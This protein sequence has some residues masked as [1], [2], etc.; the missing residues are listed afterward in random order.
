[1]TQ[2]TN[3]LGASPG[4]QSRNALCQCGSGEKYKRCCG[5]P[6]KQA[7]AAAPALFGPEGAQQLFM[8]GKQLLQT[9]QTMAAMTAFVRAVQMD[10]KHFEAHHALGAAL[11]QSGRLTDA[12]AILFQAVALRPRSAAAQRDLGASYDRQNHHEAA[13]EAYRRAVEL[14]PD[15][16]DVQLRLG[17]LYAMYSR[18]EEAAQCLERAAA[19]AQDRVAAALFRSDARLLRGDIEGA[20]QCARAAVGLAPASDATHGTLGGLLYNQG[21]FDEAATSF[22]AALKLNPKAVKCWDG[23][24]HC[25]KYGAADQATLA[26]MEAVAQRRDLADGD[27][28]VM[29]F[30]IGKVLDD[31]GEYARAMQQFDAANR[32]R[33]KDL[34]FDRAGLAAMVDKTIERFTPEFMARNATLG[35]QDETP[36]FVVGMYRSGTTLAEQILS[37]HPDITAGGELTVWSPTDIEPDAV[38][39]EFDAARIETAVAKY[40]NALRRIGPAA[41][42]VTD[43]L[44]TNFFRLGAIHTLLPRA[45][46]IHCTRDPV[47][48]CFSVYSTLFNTRMPFAARLD[49]LV[50]FYEQYRRMMDHWRRVL[51][52]GALLDV[53]YERLV[54]DREAETRR[55]V[56]FAGVAWDERCLAP[57]RNQRP[58]GTSS[59]WQARQPVYATSMARWRHYEPWLRD[60]IRLN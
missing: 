39:G 60:L 9:G 1:M 2:M 26:R 45:R 38:S 57:E 35:S 8:Q 56:A 5:S 52:A 32:F 20:E 46:I 25:R 17:Q 29:H 34:V 24:A 53:A 37:S 14:A 59:A 50:F 54:A 27:R 10:A 13:I 16:V 44:P 51:P 21:R 55:L 41:A 30:A 47:D 43:K 19:L 18:S 42:R 3:G 15:W 36:L 48:T 33:A 11:L 12:S 31:C 58:I 7:S 6:A 28:M 4:K 49:D 23:L 22:E 40:L